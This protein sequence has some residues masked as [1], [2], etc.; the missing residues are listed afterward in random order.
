MSDRR[1]PKRI[2]QTLNV[3]S[4][5]NDGI[6]TP[7]VMVAL[8]GIMAEAGLAEHATPDRALL[9]LLFGAVLGV[10]LGGGG[11][12]LLRETR[13]RGWSAEE[14]T[15][16]ALLALALLAY[17]ASVA[18][19]RQR[20]RR[21]LRGWDRL[22]VQRR[23]GWGEGG[24]LR[25]TDLWAR[26]DG[27]LAAVR[28]AG[29]AHPGHEPFLAGHRLRAAQPDGNSHGARGSVSAGHKMDPVTTAFVGWFGPRGLASVVFALLA[30]ED[31]H[32]VPG[33]VGTVVGTIG[34][35]VLLSVLVHGLS[36]RPLAGRYGRS[37]QDQIATDHPE[38]TVRRLVSRPS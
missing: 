17:L 11:G 18:V 26:L 38:P 20:L 25:R 29:G 16:P 21:R 34:L 8:A 28:C 13:R 22:R 31:L 24:L 30:L 4:G 1:V 3:E 36:A 10:V 5:L 27:G 9:G 6:A 33:P 2:R 19:G 35:T 32:E 37:R 7:V 23:A 15:G 14:F 12:L